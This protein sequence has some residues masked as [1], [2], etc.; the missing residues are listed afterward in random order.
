MDTVVLQSFRQHT[1]PAWLA[2]CMRSVQDW[3]KAQ[4]YG[5]EF[6]DDRLFDHVPQALRDK[7]RRSLLPL[8]DIARL[9]LMRDRLH[10]FERT[11]W[12]DADVLVF[13]PT[14]LQLPAQAGAM[15]CHEIWASLDEH[16]RL[17]LDRRI[18]NAVMIFERDH[19]L[20]DFLHYAAI[21]LYGQLDTATMPPAALGTGFLSRLGQLLPLRVFHQVA[22]LSPLLLNALASGHHP[23]HLAAHAERYGFAF[24]AANLCRSL[25]GQA[26]DDDGM[27]RITD[28]LLENEGAAVSPLPMAISR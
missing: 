12:I 1:V 6:V 15:L 9:G 11:V 3:A 25:H 26:I 17:T 20:P 21:E 10:R 23:E 13:R 4:G 14:L 19:P 27:S 22:C 18:N 7:P 24:H 16:G 28:L 5:Y 8:T 2:R